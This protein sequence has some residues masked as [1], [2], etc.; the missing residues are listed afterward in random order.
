M[1]RSSMRRFAAA[2]ALGALALTGCYKVQVVA[3]PTAV[4]GEAKA[5]WQNFFVFGLVGNARIDVREF[6]GG[7][8][9]ATVETGA[10]FVNGLVSGLTF[11]LYTPRTVTVTCAAGRAA[12][13][14]V[15]ITADAE[16]HPVA[17]TAQVHGRTV[18]G[19]VAATPQ[20]GVVVAS[21]PVQ[22]AY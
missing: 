16:G 4:G 18:H 7:G 11:G 5:S 17:V 3:S 12:G 22:E 8:E 19:E 10:T 2:A 15:T 21:I 6:C 9:A 1:N 13:N 14:S 20:P